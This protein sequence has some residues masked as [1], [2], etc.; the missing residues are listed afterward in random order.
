MIAADIEYRESFHQISRWEFTSYFRKIFPCDPPDPFM[1]GTQR[2]L[3][4]GMLQPKIAKA[5]H[6]YDMHASY[7]SKLR[8]KSQSK[9]L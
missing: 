2:R 5:A 8:T 9:N 6:G 3:G 4:S 7:L 1:P